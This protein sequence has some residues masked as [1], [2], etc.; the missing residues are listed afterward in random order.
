MSELDPTTRAEPGL[1]LG[2]DGGDYPTLAAIESHL[3]DRVAPLLRDRGVG[4]Y[5]RLAARKPGRG[6]PLKLLIRDSG[7]RPAAVALVA[8]RA[9]PTLVRRAGRAAR[10]VRDRLGE[11][12]GSRVLV[13][14]V[15]TQVEDSTVVV[16]P[17]RQPLADRGLVWRAQ[18]TLLRPALSLWLRG[19]A[20][21]TRRPI[22]DVGESF[23]R[24][25]R[26]LAA[27]PLAS[28]DIQQAAKAALAEVER[29]SWAPFHVL[30]HN[31]FWRGNVLLDR[32]RSSSLP[33]SRRFL[34]TDWPGA[35]VDDGYPIY[36]L[37]RMADSFGM[38]PRTLA[39]EARL[40]AEILECPPHACMVYLLA[41][42]GR[43]GLEPANF[44]DDLY[45]SLLRRCFA[46]LGTSLG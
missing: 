39:S 38:C 13:P 32:D 37:V 29:R 46:T 15:E 5:S 18:R 22:P 25:L 44:R 20:R 14:A 16:V 19:V 9:E 1:T 8:N 36:D 41:S 2:E 43:I 40:H 26:H 21:H 23:E 17:W 33:L 45:R 12:L 11:P 42:L 6:D 7:G 28:G 3:R 24:P 34:V 10:R 30:E 4:G 31:D 27:N 35:K